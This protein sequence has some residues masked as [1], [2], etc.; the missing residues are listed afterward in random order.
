MQ[1][2]SVHSSNIA[3]IGYDEELQTLEVVFRNG[4]AFNYFGV[5]VEVADSFVAAESVGRYF[6]Q[7][8]RGM[9][10]VGRIELA[11]EEP[12]QVQTL[13]ELLEESLPPTSERAEA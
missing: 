10:A 12:L 1:R 3:E 11:P 13:A 2:Q 5:P 6:H 8:I 9:F 7:H 4:T